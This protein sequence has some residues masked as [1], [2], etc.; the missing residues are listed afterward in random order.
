MPSELERYRRVGRL[1]SEAMTEV[2]S[3]A[4]PTWTE[5]QLAGAG[6]EALWA[7]GLHPALTLVAGERRLPLAA[8]MPPQPPEKIGWASN[9]SI[10]RQGMGFVCKFNPICQFRLSW[11]K[12]FTVAPTSQRN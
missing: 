6:A 4:K 5:Y 8:V 10:L 7:R 11:G 2:L 9:V 1:A 12:S 3:A